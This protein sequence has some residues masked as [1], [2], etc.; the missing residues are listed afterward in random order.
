MQG[1]PYNVYTENAK[2]FEGSYPCQKVGFR[3]NSIKF[4]YQRGFPVRSL[5]H[6][7]V[8]WIEKKD[9]VVQLH[10]KKFY[11]KFHDFWNTVFE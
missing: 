6:I 2:P 9:S 1:L 7:T 8:G 11:M 4:E 5:Y 3:L 10:E